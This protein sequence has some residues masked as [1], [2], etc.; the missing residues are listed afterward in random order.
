MPGGCKWSSLRLTVANCDGDD[1][2]R[3]VERRTV[4]MGDGIA[5]FT[6]FVDGT[7]SLRCAVRADSSGEGELLEELEQSRFVAAF[8][9]INLGVIAF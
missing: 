1:E 9:G 2:I 8:V 6:A 4:S 7:G 5:Q 3:I